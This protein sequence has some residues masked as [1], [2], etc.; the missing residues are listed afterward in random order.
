MLMASGPITASLISSFDGDDS[1]FRSLP[2][3]RMRSCS[4]SAAL[5][6]TMN[7]T[8]RECREQNGERSAAQWNY[9]HHTTLPF[10]HRQVES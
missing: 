9:E 10:D 3:F 5:L 8:T 6:L 4:R 1:A 7:R 2:E